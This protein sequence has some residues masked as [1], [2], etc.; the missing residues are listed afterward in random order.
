[1]KD[2]KI[3]CVGMRDEQ[4]RLVQDAFFKLGYAWPT[5]GATFLEDKGDQHYYLA[6]P[7]GKLTYCEEIDTFRGKTTQN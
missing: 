3:N 4:K 2:Y 7:S 6:Y 1:M 5:G